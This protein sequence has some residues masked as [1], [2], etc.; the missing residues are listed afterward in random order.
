MGDPSPL[1]NVR[2]FASVSYPRNM[3]T[4]MGVSPPNGSLRTN[5]YGNN[6]PHLYSADRSG[7][8]PIPSLATSTSD[9]LTLGMESRV[10]T[11][12]IRRLP[13]TLTNDALRGMLI[14]A[15]DLISTDFV[16]S[17]YP[18]DV[19]YSTAIARFK[20]EQGALEAQQR[21]HGKPNV[22]KETNMIV[23]LRGAS[24]P[25]AFERRNTIDGLTSRT[26]NSSAS[27]GGS[28]GGPPPGRS[29]FGSTFQ[30]N[31]KVSPPLPTPQSNGSGEFPL[32]ET[33]QIQSLFSP[34]SPLANGVHDHRYSGK[35]TINDDSVD[36]E[37]GE[38]LKDPLKYANGQPT[39]TR[40]TSNAQSVTSRF[41]SLSL[42]TGGASMSSMMSPQSNGI[43]S[44]RNG[45]MQSPTSAM[46]P[47][48]FG[49]YGAF[50]G[51]PVNNGHKQFPPV[52]P[53][54]QNPPCNTLY[55][56]NLPIDTSEDEL[57]AIFSRARGYKRLCFR[58]K[59]N[60]P[61][62]FV[63][64]E[65]IDYATRALNEFYGQPLHNSVKGGIR[66]SFSK[67]P[68]GVRSPGANGT[69]NG[70]MQN[71]PPGLGPVNGQNYS[72]V[73]GPPPGLNLNQPPGLV[74]IPNGYH[75]PAPPV[76]GMDGM[77]ANPFSVQQQHPGHDFVDQL[78]PRTMSGGLPNGLSEAAFPPRDGH[79][80]YADYRLGH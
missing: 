72:G 47:T 56:G 30:P 13:R 35:R 66:L 25:T 10:S 48:G 17:P 32:H 22:A 65:G 51:F 54:D 23:E 7:A 21:L 64:F 11:I 31:D 9:P 74:G 6:D 63:E 70:H 41:N 33:A 42:S 53:A 8:A 37:T 62:C 69:A 77:F 26:A 79:Q 73:S 40:R 29:R 71:M 24:T 1:L 3:Y 68:L 27:S 43:A 60:G 58:T 20:T 36:D 15:S 19:G 44:P 4:A 12:F 45:S 16:I 76:G 14:F 18:E 75:R 28:V 78:G 46:S 34:Q 59:Q 55:V 52:N 5:G 38:L 67:N 57:K 61:M 50:G 80:G 49:N 39:Y 2:G